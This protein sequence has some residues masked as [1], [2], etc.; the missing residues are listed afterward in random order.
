M[1][2]LQK[3]KN[4]YLFEAGTHRTEQE[5]GCTLTVGELLELLHDAVSNGTVKPDSPVYLAHND[6]Y[7]NSFGAVCADQILSGESLDE[8]ENVSEL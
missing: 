1:T 5:T 2:K 6:F 7:T 8:A 3:M 4:L